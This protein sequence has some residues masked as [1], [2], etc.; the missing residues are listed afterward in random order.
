VSSVTARRAIDQAAAWLLR[1]QRADGRFLYGYR[2]DRREV[3]TAYDTT[4]HSG[5][6]DIL[7]RLH[8]I[9]AADA[10]LRYVLVNLIDH[11][12]WT[13]FAPSGEDANAGANALLLA[14][15]L[16]RRQV[17]GS[18]RY[19]A[20]AHGIARFLLGQVRPDGSV[21]QFWNPTTERRVPG[22]FGKFST[23][24]TFWAFT[25]MR[26]AFPSEGWERPAHR[27]AGYLATRRDRV[28]G[29]TTR[30]ADH[31]AAYGLAQL[32]PVGLTSTEAAYGRW[33]A[34]G[35][36]YQIRFES[37]HV[38][39]ALNPFEESGAGLGT[40]GEG[41]AAIWRL[42]RIDPR[43]AGLRDRLAKRVTCLAGIIVSE[44][45]PASDPD[46]RARGAWFLRDYTQMDDQQHAASALLA[47]LQV[48]R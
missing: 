30:Q 37:Q 8:R 31:W 20:L 9:R 14:A 45:V 22:L 36:G 26:A 46:P 15:L 5:A 25:L 3:S 6:L 23:G 32:A 18:R 43:V 10:G 1:G 38:G 40:I 28:E 19:D 12:G 7:Y 13:A 41:E 2:R 35:F 21:L 42:S 39:R 44:Q 29:Y 27:I 4:R 17:T 48:L 11:G 47:A 24:E 34:G 33:L 16:H